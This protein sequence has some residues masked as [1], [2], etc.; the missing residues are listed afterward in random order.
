MKIAR[1][2]HRCRHKAPAQIV[3]ISNRDAPSIVAPS[4]ILTSR[5]KRAPVM[6]RTDRRYRGCRGALRRSLIIRSMDTDSLGAIAID[7]AA[8]WAVSRS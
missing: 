7:G 3:P 6:M 5:M 8:V 2:G 1:P 4:T